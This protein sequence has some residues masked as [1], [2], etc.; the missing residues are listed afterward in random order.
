MRFVIKLR[1]A[2]AEENARAIE[3]TIAMAFDEKDNMLPYMER[4]EK[5]LPG[6]GVRV[7]GQM[8]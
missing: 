2:G 3:D 6:I 7:N 4:V 8:T 1:E 5:I